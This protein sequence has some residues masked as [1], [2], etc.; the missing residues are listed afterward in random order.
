MIDQDDLMRRI[1]AQGE[2]FYA[3]TLINCVAVNLSEKKLIGI[4]DQ[5]L[6]RCLCRKLNQTTHKETNLDHVFTFCSQ[7]TKT[8]K[9]LI[10]NCPYGFTN[11]IVPVSVNDTVRGG[12][13]AGPILNKRPD[14]ILVSLDMPEKDKYRD[15]IFYE[16]KKYKHYETKQ[17]VAL[18]EILM[19]LMT[20]VVE[21]CDHKFEEELAGSENYSL[22]TCKALN[23]IKCHYH[24]NITLSDVA[25]ATFVNPSYLS[26]IFNKEVKTS[27]SAYLNKYRVEK[28]KKLLVEKSYNVVDVCLLVGFENQSYYNKIFKQFEGATPSQFRKN[29]SGV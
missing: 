12:L 24:D 20:P 28:S 8:Q 1:I 19:S 11:I 5:S 17:I 27:F 2:L 26:R 9:K 29:H 23:Y 4:P 21:Y 6:E 3:A 10:Y 16:L 15:I 13:L 14:E 25:K 7:P 22:I 18:S